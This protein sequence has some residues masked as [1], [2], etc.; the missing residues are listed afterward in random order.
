MSSALKPVE[1]R[2]TRGAEAARQ[3]RRDA[4]LAGLRDGLSGA[5]MPDVLRVVLFGSWARGD[6]DGRSDIDLLVVTRNGALSVHSLAVINGLPDAAR[7]DLVILSDADWRSGL[8][9]AN[10]FHARVEAEGVIVCG[11]R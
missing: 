8:A 5:E 6:F 4:L 10:P 1:R 3:R 7:F 9:S 11:G 2:L